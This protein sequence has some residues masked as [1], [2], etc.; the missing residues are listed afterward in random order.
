MGKVYL[1]NNKFLT[2]GKINQTNVFKKPIKKHKSEKTIEGFEKDDKTEN[3][4]FFLYNNNINFDGMKHNL[5]NN[6]NIII[7]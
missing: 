2:N 5:I 3:N 7:N 4:N 6:N 1:G